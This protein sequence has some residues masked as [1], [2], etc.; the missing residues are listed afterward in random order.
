MFTYYPMTDAQ[1][2]PC[3]FPTS[4]VVKK[5]QICVL[6]FP[7][8]FPAL[9]GETNPDNIINLLVVMVSLPLWC[10]S[11]IANSALTT[12]LRKTCCI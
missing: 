7:L 3:S 1:T 10:A 5:G 6:K 2:K 9:I 8:E 4:L 12:I 11:S